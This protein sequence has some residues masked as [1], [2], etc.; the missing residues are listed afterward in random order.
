MGFL[1]RAA[2]QVARSE[3]SVGMITIPAKRLH[4]GVTK[5]LLP[6]GWPLRYGEC[7][8]VYSQRRAKQWQLA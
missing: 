4:R 6:A 7:T 1:G 5:I 2:L 3:I 8:N